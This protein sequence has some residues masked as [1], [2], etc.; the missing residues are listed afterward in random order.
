MKIDADDGNFST[1]YEEEKK[2][3]LIQEQEFLSL[4]REAESVKDR[5]KVGRWV[6]IP[7]LVLN[8]PPP[9]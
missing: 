8:W 7:C 2:M 5:K 6:R 9:G 1:R 3:S 4:I